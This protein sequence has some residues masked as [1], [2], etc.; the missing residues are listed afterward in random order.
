[1]VPVKSVGFFI[2]CKSCNSSLFA[3]VKLYYVNYS[4][5]IDS[6]VQLKQRALCFLLLQFSFK[7]VNFKSTSLLL[8]YLPI[9]LLPA[10]IFSI[11]IL[12][13]NALR[14]SYRARHVVTKRNARVMFQKEI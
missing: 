2:S 1:M 4:F 11:P 3:Y 7:T 9:D 8:L 5:R 12:R 14:S 6:Q 10:M 13:L